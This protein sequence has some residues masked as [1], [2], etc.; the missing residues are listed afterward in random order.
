MDIMIIGVMLVILGIVYQVKPDLFKRWF[1]K[2]TSIAQRMLSPE[3]YIKYM[4]GLG[5][6]YIIGGLALC[7]FG[8][9]RM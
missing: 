4:K 8:F 6:F 9:A 1:W 2:K 7:A 3:A 5:W